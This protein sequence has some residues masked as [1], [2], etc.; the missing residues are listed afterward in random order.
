MPPATKPQL[1]PCT[2][3]R[4]YRECCA[5]YHRGAE[6]PDPRALVRSRY[7]AFALKDAAYLWRTLDE[8]NEERARGEE[9]YARGIRGSHV[10]YMG[11]VLLDSAPPDEAGLARVLFLAKLFERGRDLSFVELSDFRHDGAGFRYL[12]GVMAPLR[13]IPG[14]PAALTI[15]SFQRA[16]AR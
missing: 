3:G 6:P 7:A 11:L 4:A 5:P 9:A 8:D 2:S 10:R 16:L 1:C 12:S 15:E 13:V 14:D